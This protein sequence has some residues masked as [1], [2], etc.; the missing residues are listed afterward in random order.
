MGQTPNIVFTSG[1]VEMPD[2]TRNVYYGGTDTHM[3][4]ATTTVED[5]AR[6]CLDNA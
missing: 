5:L 4:L 6:Y 2:G 3:C 1:A